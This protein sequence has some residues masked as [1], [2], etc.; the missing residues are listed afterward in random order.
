MAVVIGVLAFLLTMGWALSRRH[1]VARRREI[2][3][4]RRLVGAHSEE[5]RQLGR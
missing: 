3:L 1:V 4:S 2:E 5:R